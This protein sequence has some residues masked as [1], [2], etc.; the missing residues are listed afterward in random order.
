MG[1]SFLEGS[2]LSPSLLAHV[3]VG[4][5]NDHLPFYRQAQIMERRHGIKVG[6]NT[7]CHWADI[8]AQATGDTFEI[9]INKVGTDVRVFISTV[10]A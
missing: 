1:V 9:L 4:K 10:T 5:F 7:L 3:L 6:D 2:L 8:G